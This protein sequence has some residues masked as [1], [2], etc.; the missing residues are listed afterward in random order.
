MTTHTPRTERQPASWFRKM[1]AGGLALLLAATMPSLVAK[2]GETPKIEKFQLTGEHWTCTADGKPLNGVI[3]KPQG[4]GPFPALI[5]SHGLGGNAEGIVR[6]MGQECVKWGFVCIATDYTHAG[7]TGAGRGSVSKTDFTQAGARPENIRR[8]LACLELLRQQKDV[9][10][11]RVAAYGFSMGAF[12]TI[13]LTAATDKIAAATIASGGVVTEH[14]QRGSAP[15][16]DV[17]ARVRA[18]FLILQGAKDTTVPPESSERF[19]QVLDKNNV[20]NERHVFDGVGHNVPKER[21]DEVNRLMR[22]WFTKHGALA[23]SS[24]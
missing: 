12:V 23:E 3:L 2:A 7:K 5:L 22:Q 9:D 13:A 11:H 16:V 4:P 17:A 20:P 14:Y 15:S 24:W 1:V 18:P 10:P 6:S 21:V 19:K 8:A